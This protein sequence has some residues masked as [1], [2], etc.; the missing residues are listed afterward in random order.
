VATFERL[1]SPGRRRSLVLVSWAEHYFLARRGVEAG[2]GD[3]IVDTLLRSSANALVA[4]GVCY[5]A[6]VVMRGLSGL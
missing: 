2:L 5:W 6:G 4:T 1:R 3:V